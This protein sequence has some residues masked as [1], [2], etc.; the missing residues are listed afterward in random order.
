MTLFWMFVL[1]VAYTFTVVKVSESYRD[2][3]WRKWIENFRPTFGPDNRDR[4][5]VHRRDFNKGNQS[6]IES[7][8]RDSW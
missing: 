7:D 8:E 1:F 2:L 3:E 4:Y 5:G 6:R